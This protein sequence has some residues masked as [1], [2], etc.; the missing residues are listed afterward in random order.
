MAS[1]QDR[2]KLSQSVFGNDIVDFYRSNTLFMYEKY[3][4]SD[5]MCSIISKDKIEVGGFYFLHYLDDSN[6]M[7]WSPIFCCDYRKFSNMIVILGVNFNFI[8][9][10]IR[11]YIFDKFIIESDF[12]SNKTLNVDFKG[13]YSELLK[14][15]FE[16]SIVEYNVSQIKVVHR[17]NLE[18]LPRFLY[19]SYPKN[20]YDPK[21]LMQIWEKKIETREKRHAEIITSILSEFYEVDKDLSNK[22]DALKDHIDRLQASYQKYGTP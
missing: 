15:G 18:L 22:Y 8:P 4:Q 9:L 5:D 1:L 19:S 16:Y 17:I 7:K 13:M 6:W 3:Y 10:E 20:I 14:F 2:I 11:G 12:K 21:K